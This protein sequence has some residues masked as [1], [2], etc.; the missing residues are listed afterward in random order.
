MA[1]NAILHVAPVD[2]AGRCLA[3]KAAIK[4]KKAGQGALGDSFSS[5]TP[6]RDLCAGIE[7]RRA[8]SR[9]ISNYAASNINAKFDFHISTAF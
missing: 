6:A 9:F 4:L 7:V 3:A 1:L 2:M 5:H 8:V